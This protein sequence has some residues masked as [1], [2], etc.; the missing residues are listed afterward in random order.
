MLHCSLFVITHNGSVQLEGLIYNLTSGAVHLIEIFSLT[1]V[2]EF[3][4]VVV[5]PKS[6]IFN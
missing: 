6:A 5:L 4:T 2:L 1:S 3:I